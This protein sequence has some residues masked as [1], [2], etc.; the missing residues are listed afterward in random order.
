MNLTC[1]FFSSLPELTGI[2]AFFACNFGED[3]GAIDRIWA[4]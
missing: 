2:M 1:K 4:F 3:L